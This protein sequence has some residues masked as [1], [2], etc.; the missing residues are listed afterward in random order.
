MQTLQTDTTRDT[1]GH[2]LRNDV[3]QNMINSLVERIGGDF[4][5]D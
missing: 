1:G 2:M 4:K 5:N 3:I